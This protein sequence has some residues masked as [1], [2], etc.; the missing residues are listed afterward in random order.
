LRKAVGAAKVVLCL[1][2]R[3]NRDGHVMR[4]FELAAM[5]AC[6]LTEDTTDHRELFGPE[7]QAVMYFRNEVE[8][9]DKLRWLLE[10]KADRQRLQDAARRLVTQGRHT[11]QDRLQAMLAAAPSEATCA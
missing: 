6:M 3:A 5:G 8:M 2:R 1:V 4:T 11:Y 9:V 10:H 7:G